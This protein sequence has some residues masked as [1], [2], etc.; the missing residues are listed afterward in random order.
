MRSLRW[1]IAV[2][3]TLCLIVAFG[4][5][6]LPRASPEYVTLTYDL[7]TVVL[8]LAA[9]RAWFATGFVTRSFWLGFALFGFAHLLL[10]STRWETKVSS[11][12]WADVI[13]EYCIPRFAPYRGGIEGAGG[14]ADVFVPSWDA[15]NRIF[16][17]S[18]RDQVVLNLT[19][20]IAWVGGLLTSILAYQKARNTTDGSEASR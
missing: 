20:V 12:Y 4:L 2:P 19:F 8:V 11:F 17:G 13:C 5:A 15:A 18:V 7:V 10:V 14:K 16:L 9:L 1:S 3:L 6:T